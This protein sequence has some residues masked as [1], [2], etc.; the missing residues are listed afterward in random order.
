MG[1]RKVLVPVDDSEFCRQIFPVLTKFLDPNNTEL[2]LL[3][4]GERIT[5]HVGA[6]P[7]PAAYDPSMTS[8]DTARDA[9]FATHPIYASQERE[10]ALAEFISEMQPEV[11]SLAEAGFDIQYDMRFGDRGEAIVSYVNHNDIDLL[12]MTTHWRTGINRLLLGNTVQYV[13]PR[14]KA[15]LLMLRP[16]DGQVRQEDGD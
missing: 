12:A 3:R 1:K 10:S 16:E 9:E 6:P 15:P 5:G 7:R 13:V 8:Y 14:I 11:H 4:V 2:I